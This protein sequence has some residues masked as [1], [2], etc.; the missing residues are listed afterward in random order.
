MSN[1]IRRFFRFEIIFATLIFFS[2][3][4]FS[5]GAES[6]AINVI[7][8]FDTEDYLLPADDDAAKRLAEMLSARGIQATFKVVGEKARVLEQRGR[9]D[10]IDALKKHD[11]GY[12]A[13]FHSVHPTPSEYLA[14]CGLLDGIEEFA[15]REGGGA[16]DVR[17]VFDRQTLSCYGQPGSSWGAQAVIALQQIGIAPHGVPCYVDEGTQIG[18][19]EKPFWFGN[20]LNVFHMGQNYT[21]MD[22]HDPKAVEPAKKKVSAIADRL[23]AEGG[24]LISIF[25]HPCE[26]VHQEFWDGVNFRRGANPPREEWKAPPQRPPEETEAAFNRFAEYID[27]IRAIPGVK[28]VTASDLP[29]LYFDPVRATSV[30]QGDFWKLVEKI[31][32]AEK[33]IDFQVI[34]NRAYSLADQFELLT[35]A[36]AGLIQRKSVASPGTVGGLLGPDQE[37][38]PPETTR[39]V[40]WPAFRD[41]ALDVREFIH[42]N[43]RVPSRV[44]I[45]ADSV[46]PADFL[47]AMAAVL[48]AWRGTKKMPDTVALGREIEVLPARHVAKDTPNLFG[49]WVIH[50][51]GF[52]AP[53]ILEIARLQAWTLKPALA[54]SENISS[55]S[56]SLPKVQA[57][58]IENDFAPDGDLAKPV[59]KKAVAARMDQ[60]SADASPRRAVATTVRL[61][62]SDKNLYLA[63]ECPFT[64]LNYFEPA[65][66][67]SERIGLWDKDVV[68]LFIAPQTVFP[69][70]YF[71]FE[72]AP[73]GEKID[74]V[75]ES[76]KA[77]FDWNSGFEAAVKVD[78][79]AKIWRAEWRIPLAV[80]SETT[81]N[82]GELWRLN[83]YRIDRANGAFLA[84]SPTLTGSFHTPDKF[85]WMEF[86]K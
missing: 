15:R 76:R 48:D 13:N 37:A 64:K 54:A 50:K 34:E 57:A 52:H 42:A 16:A 46:S 80:L 56:A 26:W 39:Q 41:A 33:G 84:F 82:P 14:E 27:H 55:V 60:Q 6:P 21:R 38:P 51:E 63:Y 78:D 18:L 9:R 68:E 11:I 43:E 8:W 1:L 61:L 5:I 53:K 40:R 71:E 73:N 69:Q 7:L 58:H 70:K 45:G 22:L 23:R 72:V 83:L 86:V 66:L 81:P 79:A 10:V 59:W 49:G 75:L 65:N 36:V 29:I 31:R 24:G 3:R 19:N 62:W 4:Y 85:G 32:S 77:N 12:H 20:A 30:P 35:T 74:L 44:F 67:N 17:R 25:Y 2:A 47:V 28:F